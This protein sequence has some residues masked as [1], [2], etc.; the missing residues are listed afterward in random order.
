[1]LC[2]GALV[3]SKNPYVDGRGLEGAV[4]SM[5]EA[6]LHLPIPADKVPP[7]GQALQEVAC[8]NLPS[9]TGHIFYKFSKVLV[10][11][12]ISIAYLSL[13]C[14]RDNIMLHCLRFSITVIVSI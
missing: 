4:A 11:Y 3:K 10:I 9:D 8:R 7:P 5:R 6:L 14:I 13:L 1:M 2:R 12:T